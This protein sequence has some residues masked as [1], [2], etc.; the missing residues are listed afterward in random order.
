M[1]PIGGVDTTQTVTTTSD[2]SGTAY[3]QPVTGGIER[4]IITTTTTTRGGGGVVQ[5]FVTGGVN[6]TR[7]ITTDRSPL[8]KPIIPATNL[9]NTT[10]T[11]TTT[12]GR[13]DGGAVY[14]RPGGINTRRTVTTTRTDG[15]LAIQPVITAGGINTRRVLTTESEGLAIQP[16]VAVGDIDQRRRITT[17]TETQIPPTL[18]GSRSSILSNRAILTSTAVREDDGGSEPEP[19]NY[20]YNWANEF[21][22]V[23]SKEEESDGNTVRGSYSLQEANG[24]YRIVDYIADA[25]GFRATIRTNEPGVDV[26]A[27]AGVEV[28]REPPPANIQ[29]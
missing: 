24:V 3:V 28:I 15:G 13:A 18:T 9:L 27:P 20:N 2:A 17:R 23:A 16:N 6:T 8:T 4:R 10:R 19:Y 5:P 25:N 7:V 21:G 29:K 14:I 12:S 22:S 11:V 26:P 1:I